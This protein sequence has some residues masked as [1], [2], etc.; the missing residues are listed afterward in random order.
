MNFVEVRVHSVRVS[1]VTYQRAAV[2]VEVLPEEKGVS[3]SPRI[4]PIWM[5]EAGADAIAVVTLGID[6]P[7]PQTHDFI[8]NILDTTGCVLIAVYINDLVG[9]TF[10]ARAVIEMKKKLY[11]VDCKPSDGI[12][13]ALRANS[14][15]F[16][17]EDVMA[18]ASVPEDAIKAQ[19]DFIPLEFKDKNDQN[20]K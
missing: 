7:R 17:A 1:T 16:V 11:N 6:V 13:I 20:Q 2:L 3:K 9:D 12:A 14:P 10:I 8:K 19:S 18:R 4:L 5:N 15:I